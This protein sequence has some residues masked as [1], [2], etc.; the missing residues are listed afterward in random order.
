MS[1]KKQYNTVKRAASI[2]GLALALGSSTAVA[3]TYSFSVDSPSQN[4]SAGKITNVSSTYNKDAQTLSFSTDLFQKDGRI[5][6]GFWVVLNTGPNPKGVKDELAIFY[7]DASSSYDNSGAATGTGPIVTAYGYNGANSSSSFNDPG[8]LLK[9]TQDG[10]AAGES[11]TASG[12][13]SSRTLGFTLSVA[14][15]N[16]SLLTNAAYANAGKSFDSNNWYGT[17]FGDGTNEGLA[18]VWLHTMTDTSV[19]YNSDNEITKLKFKKEGYYDANNVPTDVI[20]EPSSSMLLGLC[21]TLLI[22]RR[23]RA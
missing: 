23:K 6:D 15:I 19:A 10:L 17:G 7:L 14:D 12:D 5:A 22:L 2:A 8:A 13:N 3:Q 20:P 21:G 16:N 9:S 4:S 11:T 18:G 1:P